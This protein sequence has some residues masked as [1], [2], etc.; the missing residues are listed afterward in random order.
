MESGN[1]KAEPND[2][3]SVCDNLQY[4]DNIQQVHPHFHPVHENLPPKSENF[5]NASENT[6][7]SSIKFEKLNRN[8]QISPN[9]R[10]MTDYETDQQLF[11][12]NLQNCE[13][14]QQ[15]S[16]NENMHMD[17]ENIETSPQYY[18]PIKA[19]I[20]SIFENILPTSDTGQSHSEICQRSSDIGPLSSEICQS[21]FGNIQLLSEMRQPMSN[22]SQ[23]LPENLKPTLNNFEIGHD[24]LTS[25]SNEI[26]PE[27]DYNH[28]I[29][30]S[31]KPVSENTISVPENIRNT[32]MK[33]N[34]KLDDKEVPGFLLKCNVCKMVFRK[35]SQLVKHMLCHNLL[36]PYRCSYCDKGFEKV[37]HLVEHIATHNIQ[38]PYGCDVCQ[39][40]CKDI[41]DLQTH[42]EEK[43]GLDLANYEDE[44]DIEDF[45]NA[46][47]SPSQRT[48]RNTN[49]RYRCYKTIPE[50]NG[51]NVSIV[52][53]GSNQ[54]ASAQSAVTLSKKHRLFS[55][56]VPLSDISRK[57]SLSQNSIANR[58]GKKNKSK[59]TWLRN[60][61]VSIRNKKSSSAL[62]VC[63]FCCQ[64]HKDIRRHHFSHPKKILNV[65]GFCNL[66]LATK[67]SVLRHYLI[68]HKRKKNLHCKHCNL[69][70]GSEAN[71]IKH[72]LEFH[73]SDSTEHGVVECKEK[74]ES[75]EESWIEDEIPE[76]RIID[77]SQ[78]SI[79]EFCCQVH[80]NIKRHHF[81]HP[82][83]KLLQCGFC[84]LK[85][86]TKGSVTR[87]YM[88][89]HKK[90]QKFLCRICNCVFR[91]ELKYKKHYLQ[92][93]PNKATERLN[94]V[95]DDTGQVSDGVVQESKIEIDMDITSSEDSP[96]EE[97]SSDAESKAVNLA[98]IKNSSKPCICPFCCQVQPYLKRHQLEH[99]QATLTKCGFCGIALATKNSVIRHYESMHK[100]KKNLD[101]KICNAEIGS[102][103][104]YLKHFQSTHQNSGAQSS[105]DNRNSDSDEYG[106]NE[107]GE[108]IDHGILSKEFNGAAL[109]KI[110]DD[111][112]KH[113]K[114]PNS[115]KLR[116]NENKEEINDS[117][118]LS[119]KN[120]KIKISSMSV[121]EFC[122]EV[123]FYIKRHRFKHSESTLNKCGFCDL[124]LAGKNSV[125]RH[126]IKIHKGKDNLSCRICD[127]VIG[128]EEMYKKHYLKYHSTE[129]SDL[130]DDIE[131][132]KSHLGS[133]KSP[134]SDDGFPDYL[135]AANDKSI[136]SSQSQHTLGSSCKRS[137]D[138]VNQQSIP[139]DT[140]NGMNVSFSDDS[141]S[142]PDVGD[143]SF[144]DE[145]ND[146]DQTMY[147]HTNTAL[148]IPS[149]YGNKSNSTSM[150]VLSE[151]NQTTNTS[152]QS[153]MPFSNNCQDDNIRSAPAMVLPTDATKSTLW[154]NLLN[155]AQDKSGRPNH[156]PNSLTNFYDVSSLVSNPPEGMLQDPQFAEIPQNSNHEINQ[157][158]Y[159]G[160][161]TSE[162]TC[163]THDKPQTIENDG[164]TKKEFQADTANYT[165]LR[166]SQGGARQKSQK[167]KHHHSK[168]RTDNRAKDK[169][170]TTSKVK[171]LNEPPKKKFRFSHR[172]K[173]VNNLNKKSP[174]VEKLSIC[175][176]C[177]EVHANLKQHIAN[178]SK[179][180]LS[181]CGFCG[182]KLAGKQSVE[183]HFRC[184]HVRKADLV[185]NICHQFLGTVDEYKKHFLA[186]HYNTINQA[187]SSD[188]ELEELQSGDAAKDEYVKPSICELCCGLHKNIKKHRTSHPDTMQ[189]T[190]GFCGVQLANRSTV[191]RHYQ[192][193]HKSKKNLDCKFCDRL[194]GSEKKYR[195]HY[196]K[197]HSS[198]VSK[199]G[200]QDSG[201]ESES[202]PAIHPCTY[203]EAMFSTTTLLRAHE[204][205]HTE[206]QLFCDICNKECYGEKQLDKHRKLQHN[207]EKPQICQICGE[208]FESNKLLRSHVAK[209]KRFKGEKCFI[210]QYCAKKFS[211]SASLGIHIKRFHDINAKFKFECKTCGKGFDCKSLLRC[212]VRVHSGEKPFMCEFCGRGF[213]VKI[214][215]Q[216]H[217][218]RHTG[219]RPYKCTQC[220][221]SFK[222][223]STLQTHQRQHTGAKPYVCYDC[224]KAF[225]DLSNFH[226][227]RR[228]NHKNMLEPAPP[229]PVAPVATVAYN[230]FGTMSATFNA[231]NQI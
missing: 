111:S 79:C 196:L 207:I 132:S 170:T 143:V 66:N 223:L 12:N 230:P 152:S 176:F 29:L 140:A 216:M 227:H 141:S 225:S 103:R 147:K 81:S 188:S 25:K 36:R 128:S 220:E 17:S 183:R 18:Y 211:S 39:S 75:E 204:L 73:P 119:N 139:N 172:A 56:F 202:E 131:E 72:F 10:L 182:Q 228:S 53:E 15:L 201:S 8:Q 2:V 11:G 146:V 93:H 209:H 214:T 77:L 120:K 205:K 173:A 168:A 203:C 45:E 150:A 40:V 149:V 124:S 102:E 169:N 107:Y 24:K 190:C 7:L 20:Q 165:R 144:S 178:H 67:S 4:T 50:V 142:L 85:L 221:K 191:I 134:D 114:S 97:L 175:R 151:N 87:H 42:F 189:N 37:K 212:H 148:N 171:I 31:A 179:H 6:H 34:I 180:I 161:Q 215:L 217:L 47:A 155:S 64:V 118:C 76:E 109:N 104:K 14:I 153:L 49:E 122:R 138:N 123:H 27:F 98:K 46:I 198:R 115:E 130:V 222:Q 48:L 162:P 70:V 35:A 82:E 63:E 62:S 100:A 133:Q 117:E 68:V 105:M 30:E 177:C 9:V 199:N 125:I 101:C 22:T 195:K 166:S 181:K 231:F 57:N 90:K 96:S 38:N 13:N 226:S 23:S 19:K 78:L 108:P 86:A 156:N 121:C 194:I 92:N 88:L 213:R 65:C 60:R 61:I 126:Y 54:N 174:S 136:G 16:K 95:F 129:Y 137:G 58:Y 43:H 200:D 208:T 210:C 41:H 26:E 71:Y 192:M 187:A 99:D 157:G 219:N 229:A 80:P 89:L 5:H 33:S 164:S 52:T 116:P 83:S 154:D 160:L 112:T 163:S 1:F 193:K 197:H 110:N 135:T 94:I 184:V 91:S 159:S 167:D 218:N 185:C 206:K 21:T 44:A 55:S 106:L 127:K 145:D 3:Q 224:G 28:V 84:D 158:T 32:K 51:N 74:S 113:N 69:F 186:Y 59:R